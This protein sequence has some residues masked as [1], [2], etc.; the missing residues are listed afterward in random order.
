MPKGIIK[1]S[2]GGNVNLRQLRNNEFV[3]DDNY[4]S[5]KSGTKVEIWEPVNGPYTDLAG[6]YYPSA[7]FLQVS[8]YS[9]RNVSP[10]DGYILADL[11]EIDHSQP[12]VNQP[13]NTNPV[14]TG[15]AILGLV[16]LALI[17]SRNK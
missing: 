10:F 9:T 4:V 8:G 12:A 13:I 16:G 14:P 15:V 1:S 7:E 6:N 3:L 5:L 11:I 2:Q 17:F